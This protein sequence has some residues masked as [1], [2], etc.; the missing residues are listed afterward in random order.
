MPTHKAYTFAIRTGYKPKLAKE[1]AF[2][3]PE[4]K[5]KISPYKEK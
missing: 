4:K 1:Y 3:N 2:S 5:Q